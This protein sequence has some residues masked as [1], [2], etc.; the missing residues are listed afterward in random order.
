VVAV[1]AVRQAAIRWGVLG[2]GGIAAAFVEDLARL[3]GAEMVA[4]GSRNPT[5]AEAF[6]ARF[7]VPHRFGSYEELV[8]D[9][10]VD[11]V[12]V[13]TP[14]P[15]HHAGA[16]L[17]LQADKPVLV[18]KPFTL[19]ASQAWDLI[20]EA[21]DRDVFL[22][23]AMWTR[24]LPH[25]VTIDQLVRHGRLGEVRSIT[26]DLG[27]FAPVDPRSRLFDPRLGGGALL[28]IGVYLVSFAHLILGAPQR[29]LAS[30]NRSS[31]GV[32]S[33][34]SVTL[35][36]AGGQQ[37]LLLV[38]FETN[39]PGRAVINGTRARIEIDGPF[40]RP[41]SFRVID[42]DGSVES[43]SKPHDGIGLRHQAEEVAR[44]LSQGLRESTR[45]PL[46]ETMAVMTTLDR[47]RDRIGLSYPS[48]TSTT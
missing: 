47:I 13:A 39:T 38:S 17:S 36:Y 34:T 5:T 30:S 3:P 32:D 6:A 23:E 41:A 19:N 4:V 44:C 14:H 15:F 33:Q 31:T 22:M 27:G 37:A 8:V 25:I 48:T 10:D 21:R 2:T 16:S 45:M 40:F 35:E 20:S 9:P 18:E 42:R 24:F 26:A 46:S 12:Y 43:W 7:N 11:A 29:I 28:D 1:S